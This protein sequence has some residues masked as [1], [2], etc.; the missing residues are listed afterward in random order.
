MTWRALDIDHHGMSTSHKF[1]LDGKIRIGEAESG[2]GH[3]YTGS[4]SNSKTIAKITNDKC[5]EFDGGSPWCNRQ[6][7]NLWPTD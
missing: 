2:L 5:F 1:E 7:L 6:D 4:G 3:S